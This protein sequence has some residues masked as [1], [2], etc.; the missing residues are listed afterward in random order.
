MSDAD[1]YSSSTLFHL[2]GTQVAS[3]QDEFGTVTVI[4][5]RDFRSMS[6]D[7]IFEQSKMLKSNAALPVH[8]YIRAMLMARTLVKAQD[9]LL[10]GL[11]E[12][13]CFAHFTPA[14]LISWW[15]WLSCVRLY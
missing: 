5:N 4:D 15:M 10:L 3:M 14:T 2:R 6:F 12:V 9:I 11:G 1:I 8:H 13:A 7:L